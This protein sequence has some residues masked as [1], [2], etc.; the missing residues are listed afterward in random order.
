M[1]SLLT[2]YYSLL[3][4][5]YLLTYLLAQVFYH[6]GKGWCLRTL[7]PIAKGEFIMEYVGE[8]VSPTERTR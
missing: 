2:T 4:T 8:R 7:S 6:E 5:L 1:L 3:P